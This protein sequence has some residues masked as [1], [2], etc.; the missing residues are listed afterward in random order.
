MKTDFILSRILPSD[1]LEMM[2]SEVKCLMK[3]SSY[4][5]EL[6]LYELSFLI[7]AVSPVNGTSNFL[8]ISF[9]LIWEEMSFYI[10]S[11]ILNL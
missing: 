9:F 8:F 3:T 5:S 1:S 11:S 2:V 7:L 6:N 4:F 10:D